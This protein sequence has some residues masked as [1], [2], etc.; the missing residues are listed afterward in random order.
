MFL[1]LPVVSDTI[2]FSQDALLGKCPENGDD[3]PCLYFH[4]FHQNKEYQLLV[5]EDES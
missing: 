1:N 3:K 2:P 4:L 5:I